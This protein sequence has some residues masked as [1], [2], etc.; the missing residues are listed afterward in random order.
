LKDF[1]FFNIIYIIIIKYMDWDGPANWAKLNLKKNYVDLGPK[2]GWA[3]LGPIDF[4]FFFSLGPTQP[5]VLDQ[6]W[7]GPT[8]TV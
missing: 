3:D 7:L 5:F 2:R 4:L 8:F 1:L 6:N